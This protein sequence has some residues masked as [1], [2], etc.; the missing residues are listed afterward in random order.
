MRIFIAW[1]G[2]R[3]KQ[4]AT[5]LYNWIP[6]LI[7]AVDPWMSKEDIDKGRRWEPTIAEALSDSDVGIVCLTPENLQSPWLHFEAG[8]LAKAIDE[9]RLWTFLYELTPTDVEQPLAAFQHTIFDR[10]D[11]YSLLQ[12]INDQLENKLEA[13]ILDSL[14]DSLWGQFEEKLNKI[15]KPSGPRK[16]ERSERDLLEEILESVRA[17]DRRQKKSDVPTLEPYEPKRTR[18]ELSLRNTEKKITRLQKTR[19]IQNV[20]V[21]DDFLKD[22]NDLR[23]LYN[24]IKIFFS[25]KLR[26]EYATRLIKIDSIV[27]VLREKYLIEQREKV[28][29]ASKSDDQDK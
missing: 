24:E 9:S 20:A 1:S 15:P 5:E 17:I 19:D 4:I 26:D 28:N 3:S 13:Q 27:I 8:A 16:K 11:V 25:A 10:D 18:F 21:Y 6:M 29:E 2:E 22:L 12:S 14:F 7:Q 23:D